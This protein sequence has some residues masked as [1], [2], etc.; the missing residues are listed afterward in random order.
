MGNEPG[1]VTS[2]KAGQSPTYSL[3]GMRKCDCAFLAYLQTGDTTATYEMTFKNQHRAYI[4]LPA[5][6]THT[7]QDL[8]GY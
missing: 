4:S 5:I 1:Q 6:I 2:N 8:M 3:P 7:P